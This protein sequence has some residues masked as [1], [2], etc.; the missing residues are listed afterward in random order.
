[1]NRLRYIIASF[2]AP[3]ASLL[4]PSM[5]ALSQVFAEA[6]VLPDG[7]SDDAAMRGA[8]IFLLIGVPILY[9]L[10]AVFYAAAG[11]ILARCNRLQLKATILVSSAAPWALVAL[12]LPG[13]LITGKDI[14]AGVAI[15]ATLGLC[16]S[17]F[18]AIGGVA[19][20]FMAV[21]RARSEA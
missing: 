13:I 3:V 6:D 15:L 16:M 14:G 17:V 10:S 1:M 5:F 2:A 12:G 7:S 4:L 19:W 18:A 9:V 21:G 8:G 20:W 11:H